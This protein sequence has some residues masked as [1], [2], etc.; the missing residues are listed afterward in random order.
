MCCSTSCRVECPTK[1]Q[2]A[3]SNLSHKQLIYLNEFIRRNWANV[4]Y[5]YVIMV[6]LIMTMLLVRGNVKWEHVKDIFGSFVVSYPKKHKWRCTH[7]CLFV[8][9]LEHC[10]TT[11]FVS[12][13]VCA[14]LCMCISVSVTQSVGKKQIYS[15]TF[16]SLKQ[17]RK[18]W[19][20]L[21]RHNHRKYPWNTHI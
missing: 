10:N 2:I 14:C 3:E 15:V 17:H 18:S 6:F 8:W 9:E 16:L 13:S 1:R 5:C 12:M 4:A 7:F 11:A 21:Q 19:I 20:M